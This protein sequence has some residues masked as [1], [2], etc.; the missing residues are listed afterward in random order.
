MMKEIIDLKIPEGFT[1]VIRRD[2][3][4]KKYGEIVVELQ[5]WDDSRDMVRSVSH[6]ITDELC[7]YSEVGLQIIVDENL[8]K[9][10]N[11]SKT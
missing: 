2:A 5:K 8:K 1:L 6:M 7:L 11:D 10:T 4:K 9:L 3:P